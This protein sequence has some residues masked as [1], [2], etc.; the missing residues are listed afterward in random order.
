MSVLDV[1][2]AYPVMTKEDLPQEGTPELPIFALWLTIDAGEKNICGRP[3][4]STHSFAG[5]KEPTPEDLPKILD[6]LHNNMQDGMPAIVAGKDFSTSF[7][8]SGSQHV[9]H[10][11]SKLT[12]L[13][14]GV[15]HM[16][17]AMANGADE[18]VQRC[19]KA[20]DSL[21]PP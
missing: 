10:S 13:Q 6:L 9:D 16:L 3:M 20:L 19:C 4:V 15:R 12:T 21:L 17:D 7:P 8:G 18:E 5:I 1:R 14:A 11:A 2:F